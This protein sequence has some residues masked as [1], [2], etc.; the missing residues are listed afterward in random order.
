MVLSL[1]G[2]NVTANLGA[3][4]PAAVI[5]LAEHL[6]GLGFAAAS[7]DLVAQR[8]LQRRA[9]TKFLL[10]IDQLQEILATRVQDFALVR[11][12][13][14]AFAN[15][16]NL[17]FDTEDYRCL[18]DHHRGRRDRYKVRV[19]HHI[20]RKLSSLEIKCKT[21]AD[22][23]VKVRTELPFAQ[24]AFG[25][26]HREFIEDN[27]P[28]TFE[29]VQPALRVDFCRLTLV[30]KEFEERATFDVWLRF[31]GSGRQVP[32][33]DRLVVCEIKQPRFQAR[34][35]LMLALRQQ[36]IRPFRLSKYCAAASY[37]WP[38]I[39]LNRFR[40]FARTIERAALG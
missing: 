26:E 16:S 13:G 12:N 19:R 3:G 9:D 33:P 10:G 22:L 29:S 31:W 15:Y 17:Y 23:T 1:A 24:E 28:L 8:S 4:K 14:I 40:P 6:E 27:S 21:R 30:S 37:L 20:D 18:H 5:W 2:E 39:R 7:R 36:G 38:Q 35:P 11:A 32:L 34:S 25:H